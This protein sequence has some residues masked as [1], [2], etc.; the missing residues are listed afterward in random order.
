VVLQRPDG[1]GELRVD[2]G[3]TGAG[4]ERA[5]Y[6]AR[7]VLKNSGRKIAYSRLHVT[8]ATGRELPAR[9]EV[10]GGTGHWP[11][12]SGDSPDGMAATSECKQACSCFSS[13]TPSSL[14]ESPSGT[15]GSPV[16]PNPKMLAIL[17]ED[18]GAVYPIRID[19]T[20]SDEN[21]ISMNPSIP[22]PNDRVYAAVM[23]GSGNLYIGGEFTLVG[24]VIANHIAKWDGSRWSA[25]GS[26]MN[27]WVSAVAVSGSDVYA[28]G[29]FATAGG[30]SANYIAKWDGSRWS[31]LGSGMNDWVSAVAV[32]GSDVYAGGTFTMAGGVSANYIAKWDGSRWSD[33]GSGM[34]SA[35]FS[36]AVSGSDLYAGG[37]FTTAGGVSANYIAKWDGSHWFPV[38]SG[39]NNQ[40]SALALSGSDMKTCRR[41][42]GKKPST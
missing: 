37:T 26:G 17:V 41:R 24:D 19:P 28:G 13:I 25:L 18:T 14:G 7:L 34:N 38:D 21:W 16:P 20:F 2:L 27:D 1:R 12:P 8:D 22:G 39:M 3:I 33:L 36:L 29:D 15:G 40:V 42:T 6:G 5:H 32:L 30:V 31:A 4:V 10:S 9:I 11:V 23:D 35:V